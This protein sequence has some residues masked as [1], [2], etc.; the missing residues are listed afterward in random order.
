MHKDKPSKD[1]VEC[2]IADGA[3]KKGILRS[4]I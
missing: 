1:I 4:E 3:T 2:D